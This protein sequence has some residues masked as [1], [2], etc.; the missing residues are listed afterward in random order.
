MKT[1]G[2]RTLK[3]VV[4]V[5]LIATTVY[6]GYNEYVRLSFTIGRAYNAGISN[7]VNRLID[8][9]QK[10]EPVPVSANGRGVNLINVECLQ[11]PAE[12]PAENVQ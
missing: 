5:W 3:I 2:S 4:A 7:A 9:S 11:E 1:K 12:A 8:E 6:V 10:C